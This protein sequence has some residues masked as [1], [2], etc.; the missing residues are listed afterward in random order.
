MK[1]SV[2][3]LVKASATQVKWIQ[4][5]DQLLNV[6]NVGETRICAVERV[7]VTVMTELNM[8]DV[9]LESLVLRKT[10]VGKPSVVDE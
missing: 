4:Y 8:K 5:F 1:D 2:R 9:F 6:A 10:K 7:N 3:N